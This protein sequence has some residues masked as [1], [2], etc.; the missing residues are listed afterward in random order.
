MQTRL[1]KRPFTQTILTP[2]GF[3]L[4]TAQ[5]VAL[6]LLLIPTLLICLASL[7]GGDWVLFFITTFML[8]LL[9]FIIWILKLRSQMTWKITWHPT[10][11]EVEDGRYG[12]TEQWT[13]PLTTFTHLIQ[14]KGYLQSYPRHRLNTPVYGLLLAHP[15]DPFKNLLLHASRDPISEQ[16]IAYYEQK[17]GK[18]HK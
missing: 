12:P 6:A 15:T 8:L 16:T 3:Q 17:L 18:Q 9:T 7:F 1:E 14:D 2:T 10:H 13:E 4:D 5:K 11:V